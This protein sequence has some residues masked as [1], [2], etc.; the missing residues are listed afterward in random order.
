L[1]NLPPPP[2]ITQNNNAGISLECV[3][4]TI[5]EEL[6]IG[7]KK[8]QN[9]KKNQNILRIMPPLLKFKTNTSS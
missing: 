5:F 1:S 6:K 7:I 2:H 4:K 3:F 8:I 9:D